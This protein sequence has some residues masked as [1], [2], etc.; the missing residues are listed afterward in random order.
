MN[1]CDPEAAPTVKGAIH[2]AALVLSLCICSYN[3]AAYRQRP[4]PHL[5]FNALVFGGVTLLEFV[6]ILRHRS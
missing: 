5:A 2:G 3:V 4:A 1:F 6:N